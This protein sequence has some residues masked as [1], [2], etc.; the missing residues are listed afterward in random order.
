[1]LSASA[2]G[3]NTHRFACL[4]FGKAL[5][6]YPL[7]LFGIENRIVPENADFHFLAS[8]FIGFPFR[9]K[10]ARHSMLA[11]A[12]VSLAFLSLFEPDKEWGSERGAS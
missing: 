4:Q 10:D 8:V 3:L 5:V 9:P 11:L 1:M 2:I 12:N 7:A 6:V